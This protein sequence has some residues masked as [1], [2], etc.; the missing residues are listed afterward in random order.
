LN[1]PICI[2]SFFFSPE[3]N[4]FVRCIISYVS[5]SGDNMLHPLPRKFK[6]FQIYD[7]HIRGCICVSWKIKCQHALHSRTQRSSHSQDTRYTKIA[8]T[9]CVRLLDFGAS[10]WPFFASI[11][12]FAD[13]AL[14]FRH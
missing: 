1:S 14:A 8:H 11:V 2:F 9:P 12:L 13:P 10:F 4:L 7:C 5:L 6:A 3:G